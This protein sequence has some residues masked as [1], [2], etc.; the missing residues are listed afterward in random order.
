MHTL[1]LA[2][3][4]AL[5]AC[6]L[7]AG[8]A[9]AE[10]FLSAMEIFARLPVSFFDDTPEGLSED[11]RNQLVETG[12]CNYWQVESEGSDNLVLVS[13]PFGETRVTLR[14]FRGGEHDFVAALGTSSAPMC[15]LELWGQDSAGGLVPVSTPSDPP[16]SDYFTKNIRLPRDVSPAILFCLNTDGLETRPLFWGPEGLLNIPLDRTVNFVWQNGKFE[17]KVSPAKK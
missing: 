10:R 7:C 16:M 1:R 17:K 9:R 6:V 15:A 4:G 13:R 12:R 2:V 11:E 14:V 5:A 3:L 8:T